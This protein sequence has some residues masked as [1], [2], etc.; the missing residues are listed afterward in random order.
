MD[1][2]SAG[3][4]LGIR[5][6]AVWWGRNILPLRQVK[7]RL[8]LHLDC[9]DKLRCFS[10][11]RSPKLRD[12]GKFRGAWIS[13]LGT[14]ISS[15][16]TRVLWQ[17]GDPSWNRS[18]SLQEHIGCESILIP[19]PRGRF[20]RAAFCAEQMGWG[21]L[22]ARWHGSRR[23]VVREDPGVRRF[24][25]GLRRQLKQHSAHR[26]LPLLGSQGWHHCRHSPPVDVAAGTSEFL[27][28]VK[29]KGERGQQGREIRG[30]NV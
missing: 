14:S 18:Q 21:P 20:V 27:N 3:I 29:K 26:W 8:L 16:Q 12:G 15:S 13:L 23:C 28:A 19:D 6:F 24:P 7:C 17:H 10:R 11:H 2:I 30:K 9:C 4:Q 22:P 5:S 25:A 1:E